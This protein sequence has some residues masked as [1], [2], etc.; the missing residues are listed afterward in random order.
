MWRLPAWDQV[1]LTASPYVT[2][3]SITPRHSLISETS[4]TAVLAN[5]LDRPVV[6]CAGKM[7]C[8]PL[9]SWAGIVVRP[10]WARL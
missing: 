7:L 6:A 8:V 4:A 1:L 9:V 3:V 2:I 10:D 5:S